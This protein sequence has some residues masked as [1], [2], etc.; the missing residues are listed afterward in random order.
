MLVAVEPD[1]GGEFRIGDNFS[2]CVWFS[3]QTMT[4]V[5]YGKQVPTTP[6]TQS[7]A[8]LQLLIGAVLDGSTNETYTLILRYII[9]LLRAYGLTCLN[10][11]N[12]LP[13]P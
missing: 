1:T 11:F 13:Q 4:T 7:V 9:L 10:L 8:S 5:G 2:D 3:V 6:W 12:I